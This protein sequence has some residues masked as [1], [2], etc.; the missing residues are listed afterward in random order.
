[1]N[2]ITFYLLFLIFLYL[3]KAEK[4]QAQNIHYKH[5]VNA[6]AGGAG[7]Y[8][9]LNYEG[10]ITIPVDKL[11]QDK[12]KLAHSHHVMVATFNTHSSKRN[13]R[14]VKHNVDYIHTDRL[15]HLLKILN[16]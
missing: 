1:M 11:T 8:G 3:E 2:R 5:I 6:S 9:S 13:I 4:A 7:G 14:A 12:V 10:M 15:K 16:K